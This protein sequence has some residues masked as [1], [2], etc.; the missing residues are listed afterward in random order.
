MFLYLLRVL[1]LKKHKTNE[2]QNKNKLRIREQI[3]G[4]ERGW[5]KKEWVK[6]VKKEIKHR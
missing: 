2:K 4:Y 5:E 1:C 3:G 6:G